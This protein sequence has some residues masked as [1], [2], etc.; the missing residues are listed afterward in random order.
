MVE[1]HITI[2][3]RRWCWYEKAHPFDAGG[4]TLLRLGYYATEHGAC[5]CMAALGVDEEFRCV[6]D[7]GGSAGQERILCLASTPK[8]G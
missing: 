8:R 7:R 4:P 5:Q 6:R 1:S 2:S 3:E